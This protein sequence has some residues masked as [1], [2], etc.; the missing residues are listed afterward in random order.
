D[1]LG[2]RS[3]FFEGL[4]RALLAAPQPL[5]LV[6]DD[7]QWSDRET[8]EWLHFLSRFEPDARFLVLG[9]VRAEEVDAAHPL[10]G[11]LRD[12]RAA[13]QLTEIALEPLD[14]VETAAL[15]AQVGTGALDAAAAAR[16]YRE[17]EGNP[18]FIVELVR[19]RGAD[20]SARG[21]DRGSAL[22]PPKA[23]A[24]IAGR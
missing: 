13:S 12:R 11:F 17:T 6:V 10:V 21:P 19:A 2:D 15:A 24:V 9:T 16:L 14:V 3:R 18:L 7:L 8:L 20:G 1:E 4:A 5:L 23:Q 22:L